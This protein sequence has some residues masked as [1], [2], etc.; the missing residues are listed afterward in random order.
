MS[1][2]PSSSRI[3]IGE[4]LFLR[5]RLPAFV[6]ARTCEHDTE[7]SADS[8]GDVADMLKEEQQGRRAAALGGLAYA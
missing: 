5:A 7:I 3:L 8:I 4:G 2:W 6:P 1:T